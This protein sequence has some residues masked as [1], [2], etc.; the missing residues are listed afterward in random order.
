MNKLGIEHLG[1]KI[2]LGL[3]QEFFAVAEEAYEKREDLKWLNRALVGTVPAK[4]QQLSQHYYGKMP[5]N[6]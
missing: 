5:D 3:E 6:V 4:N 1:S 2:F